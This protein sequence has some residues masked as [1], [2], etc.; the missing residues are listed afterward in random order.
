MRQWIGL[1]VLLGGV[2]FVWTQYGDQLVEKREP[3]TPD[4]RWY[5][6][7]IDHYFSIVPERGGAWFFRGFHEN[8]TKSYISNVQVQISIRDPKTN[9]WDPLTTVQ[10]GTL[11]Q[12]QR[13]KF[14][15]PLRLPKGIDDP[16]LRWEI[17]SVRRR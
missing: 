11:E 17:V 16:K 12:E 2:Y 5:L 13:R 1:I 9:T 14:D 8:K 3:A 6:D 4:V 10:L 7:E 15:K